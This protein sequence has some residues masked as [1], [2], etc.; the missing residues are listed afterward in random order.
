[1]IAMTTQDFF[2]SIIEVFIPEKKMKKYGPV[3]KNLLTLVFV[4]IFSYLLLKFAPT[5]SNTLI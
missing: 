3:I 2:S 4:L 1:M 5:S